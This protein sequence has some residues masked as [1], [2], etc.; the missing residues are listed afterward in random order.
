MKFQKNIIIIFID[1]RFT[2]C[3][4]SMLQFIAS[5]F[6]SVPDSVLYVDLPGFITPSVISGNSIRPDLLF[7]VSKKCL[8]ILESTV[9]F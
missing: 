4:N 8:C 1:G 5:C 6:K 2:L 7:T 3:N 9:G